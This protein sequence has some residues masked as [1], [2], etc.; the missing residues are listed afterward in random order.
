MRLII[1]DIT[2]YVPKM[3]GSSTYSFT[4]PDSALSEYYDQTDETDEI[5]NENLGQTPLPEIMEVD[6]AV[7]ES[8]TPLE[9]HR[10]S[11]IEVE[12]DD[13]DEPSIISEL[14]DITSPRQLTSYLVKDLR[15]LCQKFGLDKKGKR[16]LLIDR[17]M[18]QRTRNA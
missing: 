5:L 2:I 16:Q 4:I 14:S 6:I 13:S 1:K 11:V 3:T 17:I 9:N 15:D 7:D 10:S 12:I 18:S 8:A